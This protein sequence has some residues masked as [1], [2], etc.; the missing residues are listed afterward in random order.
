M[1]RNS[2]PL[3]GIPVR[4]ST[5]GRPIMALLDL[6][7][8]RWTLRILWELGHEAG[9]FRDLQS[10][11]DGMSPSVLS[12]RLRELLD[13]GIVS[14]GDDATYRLSERGDELLSALNPLYTW[15]MTWNPFPARE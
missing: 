10:R 8:R 7:G 14:Q 15:A 6:L 11:C 13:A 2:T 1:T 3:P 5:T 12:Q 9:G 4:G